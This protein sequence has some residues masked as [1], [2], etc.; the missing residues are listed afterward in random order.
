MLMKAEALIE[1]N[2]N[3]DEAR[4]LINDIRRRAA[5]SV[6]PAYEPVDCNPMLANYNVGEY[7]ATGWTQ[8]YARKAVR[9]ERRIELAMEGHRWFD[10]VRWGTVVET[11][12]A[13]YVSECQFRPYY[14]G[15][16]LSEDEIYLPIPLAQ[17][18]NAGDLYK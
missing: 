16:N 1:Q 10:L 12:N 9:M 14:N 13:Y 18:D 8:D 7:A 6:D 5:R 2:K 17:V 3:L 11:V 15:A 4:T